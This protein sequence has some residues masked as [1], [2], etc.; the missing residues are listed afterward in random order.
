M[1][2]N[3]AP[4]K[5]KPFSKLPHNARVEEF[6]AANGLPGVKAKWLPDGSLKHTFSLYQPDKNRAGSYATPWTPE[7]A[8][9]L[10][11]L[12]FCNWNGQ[13]FDRLDGNG[14]QFSVFARPPAGLDPRN[15]VEVG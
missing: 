8:E 12:G 7:L 13:P 15:V 2:E 1:N 10:N 6:L 3:L 9:K 5:R 4:V 11:A 14:G